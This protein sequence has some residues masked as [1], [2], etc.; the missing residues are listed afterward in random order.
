MGLGQAMAE[1]WVVECKSPVGPISRKECEMAGLSGRCDRLFL[2]GFDA[3]FPG[4]FGYPIET[5][6]D[7]VDPMTP[8]IVADVTGE[9]LGSGAAAQADRSW[10]ARHAASA[11]WPCATQRRRIGF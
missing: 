6:L 2:G 5:G 7:P 4:G 10:F 11:C 8:K 3:D 9:T 1:I